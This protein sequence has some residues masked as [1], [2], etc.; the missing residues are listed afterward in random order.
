VDDAA[1]AR[2]MVGTFRASARDPKLSHAEALR[3]AMLAM[4]DAAKT[5]AEADP[6][7]WAPFVVAGEPGKPH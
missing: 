6:Q 5:D 2:L 3:E 7:L 4:I 1:T